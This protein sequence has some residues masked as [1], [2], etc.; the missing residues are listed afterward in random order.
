[1]NRIVGMVGP[2]GTN[3][4]LSRSFDGYFRWTIASMYHPVGKSGARNL[5]AG[6]GWI[7]DAYVRVSRYSGHSN[8]ALSNAL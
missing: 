6:R 8:V 4:N 1:M 5:R 7:C 3:E 2:G